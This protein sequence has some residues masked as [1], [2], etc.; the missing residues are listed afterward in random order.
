MLTPPPQPFSLASL[1]LAPQVIVTP[2]VY[3]PPR[4]TVSSSH[5]DIDSKSPT[6][7]LPSGH[8]KVHALLARDM[9]DTHPDVDDWYA[10]PISTRAKIPFWHPLV[11]PYLSF[12]LSPPSPSVVSDLPASHPLLSSSYKAGVKAYAG[13][14]KVH[15]LFVAKS[16]PGFPAGHV[17]IDACIADPANHPLYDGHPDLDTYVTYGGQSGGGGGGS[18]GGASGG[19]KGDVSDLPSYHPDVA[20]F[21]ARGEP[22]YA[23]HTKVHALYVAANVAGFPAGHVNIDECLA[24]PA[25]HPLFAGH[26][27]LGTPYISY[28]VKAKTVASLPNGHP[29]VSRAYAAG[30]SAYK[31]HPR[32]H[33][34]YKSVLGFPS[35]GHPDVDACLADPAS[36]PL[37]SW[38]PPLDVFL[39]YRPNLLKS[40]GVLL[41]VFLLGLFTVVASAKWMYKLHKWCTGRNAN[42]KEFHHI[43]KAELELVDFG[44]GDRPASGKFDQ[45]VAAGEKIGAHVVGDDVEGHFDL[46]NSAADVL[47]RISTKKSASMFFVPGDVERGGASAPPPLPPKAAGGRAPPPFV[48]PGGSPSPPPRRG[49]SGLAGTSEDGLRQRGAPPI[50]PPRRDKMIYESEALHKQH[51]GPDLY[52]YEREHVLSNVPPE[53]NVP[54][55]G[56]GGGGGAGGLTEKRTKLSHTIMSLLTNYR[57]PKTQ[58]TLGNGLFFALYLAIHALCLLASA[59]DDGSIDFGRG[60]GSLAAANSAILVIPATRNSILTWILGLPFDHVVVYHRFCGRCAILCGVIHFF[61]FIKEKSNMMIYGTGL[62]A[63]L[64]GC[65]IAVTSIDRMRRK[66]FEIFFWSHYSFV[67]Y[68]T[69]AFLH[70][71]ECRPFLLVGFALYGFDRFLRILWTWIPRHTLVFQNKGDGVAQVRFRKNPLTELLGLHGVGQYYFVSPTQPQK[72]SPPKPEQN[73]DPTPPHPTLTHLSACL[74]R[75]PRR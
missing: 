32:V 56:G 48:R 61:F 28:N 38:H 69:L 52:D 59:A 74:F 9:P 34:L 35:S 19:P 37:P 46:V 27:S 5:P 75:S 60:F 49:D 41:C 26:P 51:K 68:Y 45:Q 58:K 33:S 20:V 29:G 25:A 44:T 63:L 57:I 71:K 1:L 12:T 73:V 43:G 11:S 62:G 21:Y 40:A 55:H 14:S 64:F 17:N 31:G 47:D 66:H 65:V 2:P 10:K 8:V 18:G 70:V 6:A 23:G 54:L 72:N 30:N 39:T 42:A 13:H 50:K 67:G 22:A 4:S 7:S 15:D 24:D 16:L 3:S 36:H 53:G